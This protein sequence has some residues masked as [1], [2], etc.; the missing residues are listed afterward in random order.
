MNERKAGGRAASHRR[1]PA[2]LLPCWQ[3]GPSERVARNR[4][5]LHRQPR[6]AISGKKEGTI[7]KLTKRQAVAIAKTASR[8]TMT[9]KEFEWRDKPITFEQLMEELEQFGR[10]VKAWQHNA[11][12]ITLDFSGIHIDVFSFPPEEAKQAMSTTD[13]QQRP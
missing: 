8:I 1:P 7:M 6:R 4:N 13:E 3:A 12:T 9:D 2:C 11:T 10:H 5:Q